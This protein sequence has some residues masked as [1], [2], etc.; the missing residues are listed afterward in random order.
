MHF[1]S[2][3]AFFIPFPSHPILF[4]FCDYSHVTVTD[5]CFYCQICQDV[6]AFN[7]R[8]WHIC[9]GICVRMLQILLNWFRGN[10]LVLQVLPDDPK[11]R[12]HFVTALR[13]AG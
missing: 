2:V 8:Y 7:L 9:S 3:H 5:M 12:Q 4:L 6:L 11:P 1:T 13:S 10:I